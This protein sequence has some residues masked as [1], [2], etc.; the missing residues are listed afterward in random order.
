MGQEGKSNP[1]WKGGITTPKMTGNCK[2][3]GSSKNVI[4]EHRDGNRHNNSASNLRRVCQSCHQKMTPNKGRHGDGKPTMSKD[5][6]KPVASRGLQGSAPSK[7]ARA[8]SASTA[9]SK[10]G[11]RVRSPLTKPK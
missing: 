3:C 1:N 9:N 11:T 6:T 10:R 8:K 5:A 7:K 2:V 4:T